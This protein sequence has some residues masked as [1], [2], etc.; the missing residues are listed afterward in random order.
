MAFQ[1]PAAQLKK[2]GWWTGPPCLEILGWRK[3]LPPKDFHGSHD[4]WKVRKEELV[5]MVVALQNC[6]VRSGTHMGV[7]CGGVQELCL[8]LAPILEGEGLLSL[9]VLDVVEKDPVVSHCLSRSLHARG[10]PVTRR[11]LMADSWNGGACPF[12]FA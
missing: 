12:Y 3:Y 10:G 6:A 11:S 8:C 7:L 1:L 9:E 4:Y 2:D 5:A